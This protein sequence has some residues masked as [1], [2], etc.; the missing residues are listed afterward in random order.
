LGA[1][2]IGGI[3][4]GV[5]AGITVAA[6]IACLL[7]IWFSK[8]GYDFYKARSDL[9]SAG[10]VHNPYFAQNQMEGDMVMDK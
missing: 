2:A 8:K 10:A 4:G 6:I 1:S 9:G 5:I 3:T 7:A